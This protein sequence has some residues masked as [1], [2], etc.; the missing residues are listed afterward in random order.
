MATRLGGTSFALGKCAIKTN[1]P[2]FLAMLR[3]SVVRDSQG[4]T[5][6]LEGKLLAA[7]TDELRSVCAELA[8]HTPWPRL[9]LK[10]VSYVDASGAKLLESLRKDGFRLLDCSPYVSTILQREKS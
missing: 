6:K 1:L 9:D 10:Q 3:I 8:Q 2:K 7:W 5:L 4:P